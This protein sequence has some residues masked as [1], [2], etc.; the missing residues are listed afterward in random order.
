MEVINV[1]RDSEVFTSNAYLALGERTV[2]VDAGSMPGVEDVIMEHTDSLDAVLL[3]HQHSDHVG[4]LD[5]VLD[6]Y[7]CPLV[8]YDDHPRATDY[9]E[10]GDSVRIA[11]KAFEVVYT[12]GHADD[13]VCF[14]GDET[15]FTGDVVV[16]NDDAFTNGSFGR[17]DMPGQSRELL[18][19]SI[20]ELLDRMGEP[21]HMYAGH[22]DPYSGD[23]R[24]VVERALRRAEQREPKYQ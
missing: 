22:G 19:Q 13:H 6:S 7:D 16:Y 3:T 5:A 15:V 11:E 12:P 1:T 17:T 23:V 18:I 24:E 8:T 21:E 9:F 14:L 4:E 2:L 20:Q 10:D